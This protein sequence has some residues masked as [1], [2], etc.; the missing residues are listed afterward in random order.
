MNVDTYRYSYRVAI[1]ITWDGNGIAEAIYVELENLGHQ[2]FYF[3]LDGPVPRE[4]EIFFLFGPF[5]KFLRIPQSFAGQK[6]EERPVFVYWNTEGLPDLRLPWPLVKFAGQFRS[7]LGRLEW[8]THPLG[9][10]AQRVLLS[11][12]ESRM[13]RFRYVGDY[14]YAQRRGWIDVFAD[15]SALYAGIYRRSGIPALVAPFGSSHLWYED[16]GLERDIDVLWMGKRATRRR[17]ETLDRLRA[18]LNRHGVDIY[19]VDGE[20]HPFVFD[21]ERTEILNRAK[22]TLN[23]LR[24]WYDENSL[25][26]CMAAPNGSMV[27]SEPMLPHVPQYQPG[28]HYAAAPLDRLAQTILYYL[29][30]DVERERLAGNASRLLTETL[31][32]RRSIET[33]I[34]AVTRA[35]PDLGAPIAWSIPAMPVRSGSHK[36]PLSGLRPAISRGSDE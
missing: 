20:E 5:G 12:L 16:L 4:A 29:E 10:I 34:S 28:V 23:L 14:L 30:H 2:P 9:Q 15:I 18:E 26:I 33:I 17:S 8:S 6:R 22:I 36:P 3:H 31:T 25:R 19:M 13:I 27:V 1:P 21:E 32:M 11:R 24:T 35:R 7:W